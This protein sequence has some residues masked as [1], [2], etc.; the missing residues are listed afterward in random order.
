MAGID[1]H[2]DREVRQHSEER[3]SVAL[4]QLRETL[5]RNMED[6]AVVLDGYEE[7]HT[8]GEMENSKEYGALVAG[9][10]GIHELIKEINQAIN[11]EMK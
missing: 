9:Y 6:V 4:K 7:T 8:E 1:K 2:N 10:F 5:V 11:R 3:V